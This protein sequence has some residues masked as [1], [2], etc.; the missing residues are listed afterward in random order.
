MKYIGTI[1]LVLLCCIGYAQPRQY[2]VAG[3]SNARGRGVAS[4]APTVDPMT[5]F[6]YH[7]TLNQLIHLA[8]PVG[9]STGGFQQAATGSAWPAFAKTYHD[10]TGDTTIIIQ[11]ARGGSGIHPLSSVPSNNWSSSGL[12]YTLCSFKVNQAIALTNQNLDGIIWLQGETDAS[13]ISFGGVG[14]IGY[15]D[16]LIDLIERFRNDYGCH[17][18]FYIVLV[19]TNTTD[20]TLDE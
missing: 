3:Q 17:I 18:P 16:A 12:L 11:A 2:L 7:P 19:G 5:S 10:L 13:R 14:Q 9:V 20:S 4:L 6:E 8:A 1:S 15:R